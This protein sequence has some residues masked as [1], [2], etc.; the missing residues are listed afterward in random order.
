MM[1]GLAGSAALVVLTLETIPS[2]RL[3]VGYILLFGIGSIVGMALLSV[4]IAVPRLSS[5]YLSRA[6]HAMTALVGLSSCALGI[7]MVWEIGSLK[8]LIG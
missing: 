7:A 8:A 5:G 1:H 4:V 2:V 6:H 3:G